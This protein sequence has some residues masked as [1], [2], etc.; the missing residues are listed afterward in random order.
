MWTKHVHFIPFLMR[1]YAIVRRHS[2][3]SIY[4]KTN[5]IY[6]YMLLVRTERKERERDWTSECERKREKECVCCTRVRW[7]R[8]AS[9]EKRARLIVRTVG[10]E[11][12]KIVI[13][14]RRWQ[15]RK[16]WTT[17]PLHASYAWLLRLELW[18][19][20]IFCR[21]DEEERTSCLWKNLKR[22]SRKKPCRIDD[23][24][25]GASIDYH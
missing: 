7:R 23:V 8:H 6:I 22:S 1:F 15:S 24:I 11:K 3:N 18:N 2:L 25:I 10:K 13:I 5:Y 16:R 21:G 12:K 20:E 9:E 19:V 14:R 4:Q 17:R